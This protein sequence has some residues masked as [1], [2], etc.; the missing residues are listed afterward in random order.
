MVL[1]INELPLGE[2]K[3][4]FKRGLGGRREVVEGTRSSER[5]SAKEAPTDSDVRAQ[6]RGR[7]GARGAEG[8]GSRE[9]LSRHEEKRS[10]QC[11]RVI[12]RKCGRSPLVPAPAPRALC[13]SGQHEAPDR[14]S[15]PTASG[16]VRRGS[17]W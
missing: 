11:L 1:H 3:S 16:S 12:A 8:A 7:S 14:C 4:G 10:Q 6:Q 9:P 5:S 13:P 17:R 2:G 15:A